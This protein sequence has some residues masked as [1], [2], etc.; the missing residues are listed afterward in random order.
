MD[1]FHLL[2]SVE[3]ALGQEL[4]QRMALKAGNENLQHQSLEYLTPLPAVR[5][6]G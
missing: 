5:K 6:L 4:R 1:L 3:L 2:V